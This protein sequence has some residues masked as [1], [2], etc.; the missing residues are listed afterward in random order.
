M[1][2][3]RSLIVLVAAG[4]L[5]SACG[6]DDPSSLDTDDPTVVEGDPISDTADQPAHPD[7]G[8]Q[9][10]HPDTPVSDIGDDPD[11]NPGGDIRPA[12]G[13]EAPAQQVTGRV[14]G[15]DRDGPS[16]EIVESDIATG[17]DAT[18]AAR[19]AGE[20]GPGEEWELDFYVT[21]GARRWVDIDPAAVVVVYDC[22]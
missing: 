9:L 14:V 4:V 1:R 3:R 15:V 2:L 11:S 5:L 17:T 20:I 8:D 22:T 7:A 16:V 19:A 21:E 12:D 13:E 18:D 6:D 10:V